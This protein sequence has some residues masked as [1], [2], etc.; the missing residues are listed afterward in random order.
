MQGVEM[1]S[2][3]GFINHN[4]WLGSNQ[5]FFRKKFHMPTSQPSALPQYTDI[6]FNSIVHLL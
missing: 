1:N 6:V 2:N 5:E 4:A 3:L